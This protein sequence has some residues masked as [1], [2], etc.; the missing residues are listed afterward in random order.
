MDMSQLLQKGAKILSP[1]S[2]G[3]PMIRRLESVRESV[4]TGLSRAVM[5]SAEGLEAV[6]S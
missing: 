4:K 3:F 2:M 5:N 6:Q 1:R